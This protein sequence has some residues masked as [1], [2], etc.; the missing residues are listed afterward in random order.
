MRSTSAG[1]AA[2]ALLFSGSSLAQQVTLA[3]TEGPNQPPVLT[4]DLDLARSLVSYPQPGTPAKV[5]ERR[6]EWHTPRQVFPSGEVRHAGSFFLDRITGQFHRSFNC[7]TCVP[8][9]LY[10]TPRQ[11]MF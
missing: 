9:N 3:C 10:C 1:L 6:I 2:A 8:S 11:R 5:T 4:L 7:D